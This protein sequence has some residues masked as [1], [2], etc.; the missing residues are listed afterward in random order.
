M[1]GSTFDYL[2]KFIII[3]NS[4]VGKSNITIRFLY[5]KFMNNFT[6]TIGVEYGAKN[7]NIDNKIY[8]VQIWDTAGQEKDRSITR[9]YY[10]NCS[11]AIVVYDITNKESFEGIQS[12][13]NDCK[14]NTRNPLLFVLIGNKIDLDLKGER[15]ITYEEGAKFANEKG[16]LFFEVSALT[17]ENIEESFVLILKNI[18]DR[19]KK[20]IYDLSNPN[21]GIKLGYNVDNIIKNREKENNLENKKKCCY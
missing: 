6:P 17:K 3:G 16:M 7:M 20:G 15:V 2:L 1:I 4:G 9:S 13:V 11:C 18:S 19:I 14:K 8:H 5:D 10:T 12:W 21:C